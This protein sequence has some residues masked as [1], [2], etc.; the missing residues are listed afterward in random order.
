[1]NIANHM[2]PST[3]AGDWLFL[4]AYDE[5]QAKYQRSVFEAHPLARHLDFK[6]PDAREGYFRIDIEWQKNLSN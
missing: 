6:F 5:T 3:V 2:S 4:E 1:M